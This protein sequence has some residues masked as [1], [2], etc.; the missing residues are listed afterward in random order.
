MLSSVDR[1]EF[2]IDGLKNRLISGCHALFYVQTLI[3]VWCVSL[4]CHFVKSVLLILVLIVFFSVGQAVQNSELWT[5]TVPGMGV[6]SEEQ[7]Y[8]SESCWRN[9]NVRW[10]KRQN[11]N[12]AAEENIVC[13][14]LVK[15]ETTSLNE[16]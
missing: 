9:L 1:K 4:H 15:M 6:V 13:K 3:V 7:V 5:D 2:W 8:C 16:I 12:R 11:R 10:K 14:K